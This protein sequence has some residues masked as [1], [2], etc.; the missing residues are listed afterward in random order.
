M[1][2][3]DGSPQADT[4]NSYGTPGNVFENPLAPDEPTTSCPGNVYEL[5]AANLC[6]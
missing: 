3:R 5:H 4:R 6:L 1:P 2:G